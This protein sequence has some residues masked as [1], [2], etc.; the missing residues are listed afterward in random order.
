MPERSHGDAIVKRKIYIETTIASY[1]SAWPSR[2]L[3]TAAHQQITREW[4]QARRD[5]FEIFVSQIVIQEAG[6]G[7]Q[8][9]AARRLEFLKELSLL[10]LTEEVTALAQEL[11]QQVPLPERAALDALHIAL[12]VVHG[13]D[14][15][16]TWNC[17]HIANAALRGKIEAVCRSRGYEPPVICTPEELLEE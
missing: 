15:L 8:D 14:Y 16:L 4:W 1:L 2:D 3:V 11:I 7:D 5:E 9:A 13:M 17:T 10:E 12:A 6:G